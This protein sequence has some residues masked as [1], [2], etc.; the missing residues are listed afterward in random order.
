[1][2][3]VNIDTTC[4][5]YNPIKKNCYALIDHRG[6]GTNCPFRKTKEQHAAQRR[7]AD[8]RLFRLPQKKQ[9]DIADVYYKG[10]LPWLVTVRR[11]VCI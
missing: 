2:E 5:A 3:P 6:C 11:S 8:Y 1:M 10:Q 4:F 9:M 7:K